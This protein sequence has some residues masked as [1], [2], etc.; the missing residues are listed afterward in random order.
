MECMLFPANGT[1]YTCSDPL[2]DPSSRANII[3]NRGVFT[4]WSLVA[5][6]MLSN[7]CANRMFFIY[8]L[9]VQAHARDAHTHTSTRTRSSSRTCT[10]TQHTQYTP[11]GL[12]TPSARR[13]QISLRTVEILRTSYAK[14]Q[15]RWSWVFPRTHTLAH[16]HM[17]A[18]SYA[19]THECIR[20]HTARWSIYNKK[21]TFFVTWSM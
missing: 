7:I 21:L 15:M 16:S 8:V 12:R 3:E 2:C 13:E 20:M 17:H 10:H 11:H 18:P 9:N 14:W 1:T 5:P 6:N 19:R 4:D